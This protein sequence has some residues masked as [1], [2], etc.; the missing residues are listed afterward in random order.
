M[1]RVWRENCCRDNRVDV[2]DEINPSFEDFL[3]YELHKEPVGDFTLSEY[4][5]KGM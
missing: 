1:K 5:E 2:A 4:T 3:D